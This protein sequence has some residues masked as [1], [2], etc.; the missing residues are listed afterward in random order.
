MKAWKGIFPQRDGCTEQHP[1]LFG[2]SPT[3]Q[4]KQGQTTLKPD[5]PVRTA[6][7]RR[8]LEIVVC[9]P[10]I[11]SSYARADSAATCPASS[12]TK[13]RSPVMSES[14]LNLPDFTAL[15]GDVRRHATV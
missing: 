5:S 7:P 9:P 6:V 14:S 12:L 1:T 8:N 3:P 4:V 11:L 13:V 2:E 15:R 10:N